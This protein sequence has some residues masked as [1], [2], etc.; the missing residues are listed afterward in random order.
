M[1]TEVANAQLAAQA[2]STRRGASLA[3]STCLQITV[4]R[5]SLLLCIPLAMS[6]HSE[7]LHCAC[8][9]ALL[10]LQGV[11][12]ATLHTVMTAVVC[13]FVYA[14]L[15]VSVYVHNL[16]RTAALKTPYRVVQS[17]P[18]YVMFNLALHDSCSAA[19][20]HMVLPVVRALS[21]AKC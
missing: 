10:H 15:C 4:L 18:Q 16:F 13:V 1:L 8:I 7:P 11:S 5:L 20:S 9:A 12:D 2:E 14:G 19:S 6:C 21:E 3:A 17:S